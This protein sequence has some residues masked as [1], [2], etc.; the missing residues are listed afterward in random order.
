MAQHFKKKFI[1]LLPLGGAKFQV[2]F[3]GK[4]PVKRYSIYVHIHRRHYMQCTLWMLLVLKDV[5][6]IKMGVKCWQNGL[7]RLL[8]ICI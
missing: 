6:F 7:Q 1:V 2:S 3:R 8:F 4:V 5:T